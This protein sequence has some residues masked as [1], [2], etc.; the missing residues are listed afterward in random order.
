MVVPSQAR[1]RRRS[2]LALLLAALA[3]CSN[4]QQVVLDEE[5]VARRVVA[6]L[7]QQ[8]LVVRGDADGGRPPSEESD[9]DE[10]QAADTESGEDPSRPDDS[11]STA[12]A[13]ADDAADR[14]RAALAAAMRHAPSGAAAPGARRGARARPT[15][16]ATT[17]TPAVATGEGDSRRVW[18][19]VADAPSL[20]PADALVTIVAFVDP[21]CPFCARLLPSLLA[22]REAHAADVRLVVRLRPLPFHQGAWGASVLLELAKAQ[23]GSEGFFAALSYLYADA[24]QRSLDRASLDRHAA[25]LGLDVLRLAD[26]LDAPNPTDLD[27]VIANDDAISESVPVLGTP[28]MLFNGAYVSGAIPRE[29]VEEILAFELRRARAALASG[30]R[31]AALYDTLART[32]APGFANPQPR[33]R[34]H[35]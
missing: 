25:A 30:T 12:T 16:P 7:R 28:A 9:G 15:L 1:R 32:A 27:R 3:G 5:R 31:R 8:G 26:A 23:R 17:T 21:E 29:R 2:L 24:N 35:P 6:L 10:E 4:Q 11:D 33:N 19:P 34:P 20:G 14:A 13:D 18:V 22:A